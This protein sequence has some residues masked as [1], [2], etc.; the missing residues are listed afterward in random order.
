MHLRKLRLSLILAAL[1][2]LPPSGLLGQPLTPAGGWP[3]STKANAYW[4]SDGTAL[5]S[6]KPVYEGCSPITAM[7]SYDGGV[8]AAFANVG[9]KAGKYRVMWAPTPAQLGQG[10]VR[11]EGCSPVTAMIPFRGGVLTAFADTGCKPGGFAVFWSATGKNLV[12]DIVYEGCSP[13]LAMTPFKN[14]VIT[15]VGNVGC[16]PN[17]YAAFWSEDGKNLVSGAAAVVYRGRSPI[18]AL[19]ASKQGVLTAFAKSGDVDGQYALLRSPDGKNLGG[20]EPVYTGISPV[21]SLAPF[22]EGVL[23]AFANVGGSNLFRVEYVE[24][25][26]FGAG[27]ERYQGISP[28]TAVLPYERG[29]AIG[30]VQFESTRREQADVKDLGNGRFELGWANFLPCSK[31]EMVATSIPG[32]SL[33]TLYTAEQRVYAFATISTS[34]VSVDIVKECAA[35]AVGSCGLASLVASPSACVPAFKASLA[36]CLVSKTQ[37]AAV[38]SIQLSKESK[39][40]W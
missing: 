26:R 40:L 13:V 3:T 1:L 22:R 24:N 19:T 11:Y 2:S 30:V 8:L 29:V 6:R 18:T 14:G 15:A 17:E 31:V 16:V 7:A 39:C 25:Q 38:N 4:S 32:I 37:D 28:V 10:D 36:S 12:G 35:T 5:V 27:D 34:N 33:P 20:G 21:I 9:C 23:A